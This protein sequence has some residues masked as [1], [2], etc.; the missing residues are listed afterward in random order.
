MNKPAIFAAIAVVIIGAIAILAAS[1]A[2]EPYAPSFAAQIEP[3]P[4]MADTH[5]LPVQQIA[6]FSVVFVEPVGP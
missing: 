6:D 5:G 1:T 3:L 4:M 2:S